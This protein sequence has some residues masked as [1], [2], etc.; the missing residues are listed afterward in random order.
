MSLNPGFGVAYFIQSLSLL[1]AG[2]SKLLGSSL[3]GMLTVLRFSAGMLLWDSVCPRS[4]RLFSEGAI[5][6]TM[7]GLQGGGQVSTH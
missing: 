5:A 7:L 6:L 4:Q 2:R 1:S 3:T